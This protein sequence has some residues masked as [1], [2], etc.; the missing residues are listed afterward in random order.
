[1]HLQLPSILAGRLLH[2]QPDDA[3]RHGVILSYNSVND[4]LMTV[5]IIT[6][7]PV[8]YVNN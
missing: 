1:M 5:K 7:H 8:V 4:K 2:L 3:P 6:V